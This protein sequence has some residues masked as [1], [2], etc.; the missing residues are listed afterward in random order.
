MVCARPIGLLHRPSRDQLYRHYFQIGGTVM[1]W[2]VKVIGEVTRTGRPG[3]THSRSLSTTS[4]WT[5]KLLLLLVA[6]M[7][8][9]QLLAQVNL[10]EVSGQ[11][12]DESGAALP[13]ASVT[14]VNDQT[15]IKRTTT[16]DSAGL[17]VLPALPAGTYVIIVEAPGFASQRLQFT[18]QAGAILGAPFKLSVATAQQQ[19]SVS[20]NAGLELETESHQVGGT[21]GTQQLTQLP[22]SGRNPLSY[23]LVEPG[24][25][26]G[27]D[28]AVSTSSAQFFG[29]TSNSIVLGGALDQQTGYLQDGVENVTLLTQT[30]NILP[31]TESIGEL[32]VITNGADA[33][34]RQPGIISITTKGGANSFHG[35]AYDFLQNDDLNA[36]SYNL[37]TTP[38]VKTPLRYNLFGANIGGPIVRNHAFFF[39]D[40]SGLRS[41]NSTTTLYRVPTA[42]ELQGDFTGDQTLYDPTS[43][44]P[45]TKTTV[46]YVSETG[47]NAIP[48]GPV[49]FDKFAAAYSKY[50]PAAN[51]PLNTALNANYSVPLRQTITNNQYLTRGDWAISQR[52]Q[53]Y[54]AFGYADTPTTNP[55][56][57]PGLF[58]RVYEGKATNVLSEETHVF[59]PRLVNSARFGY[60]RSNYFETIQGAG[61]ENYDQIFGLNNLDPLPNQWAP[62]T[63]AL[64]SIITL[65]YA[66]APQGA[67]QNRFQGVD[68]INLV[69]GR[70]SLFFGV[71]YIRTLFDGN[72]VIANNGSYTFNGIFTSQYTAGVRSKTN[73]GN[74]LADFLLGYPATTSGATGTSAGNFRETE[75]AGFVQDDWKLTQKLT[76]NLGLRYQFDNPPNDA[77]GHSSIYDAPSNQTIPGTWR[78]NYADFA[79]RLGFAYSPVQDTVVRGGAGIYYSQ[80]PYNY[81]QFL[82]AHAPNFIPQA[83]TFQI[84]NR[85]LTENVFVANPSA[86]GQVPQTLGLHAPDVSAIEY[87]LFVEHK[88][89]QSMVATLGYAGEGG[90]HESE[91]LNANQPD[92]IAA[93]TSPT[94]YNQRPL[95]Y[96]GDVFAQYNI[97]SSNS[98]ELQAKL[99]TQLKGGGR[100]LASYAWSKALNIEDG[101]RFTLPDEY[102][103]R[104]TYALAAWDRTNA[105]VLSTVYPLPFGPGQRFANNSGYFTRLLVAGWQLSG[106]YRAATGL[107]VSITQ[108]NVLNTG[109]LGTSFAQKICD[110][111]SGFTRSKAEWFNKACFVQTAA[112]T[113]G[114]GGRAGVRNAPINNLDFGFDKSF[115]LTER[116][117]LQFRAEAF[118]TFNHPQFS[119]PGSIAVSS[120]SLGAIT[121][122]SPAMRTMQLALRYSF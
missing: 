34:Y 33:R 38:Q 5:R 110:P 99:D 75:I 24:T 16:S 83:P 42:A 10:G 13:K 1:S 113:A 108:T 9:G 65:G 115:P 121:G 114:A 39:F 45:T 7:G 8:A 4:L 91:R 44:N 52:D 51:I 60:N 57:V 101:D 20:A 119:L 70:H 30:A 53:V 63:V 96:I 27:S 26:A 97:G 32:A 80:P 14:A 93:G 78:T 77:N 66:F 47:N 98:N 41:Q 19:V 95:S 76:L 107:P 48:G 3:N 117:Q 62:P 68:Q 81:I 64:S 56:L 43:Y 86:V 37:T 82:L 12:T 106:I 79:P 122:T 46:S 105:F 54:V 89:N 73:T 21:V 6:L 120:T 18:V 31:S 88:F 49:S 23:A 25:N 94:G 112:F 72:W 84:S 28:P 100:I 69:R 22:V 15:A 11:I 116:Q 104:S 92:S 40:Y 55:T 36:A 85:T 118:N 109:S 103:T 71:D 58:G 29:N 74:A 50:Y 61:A 90:R 59:S 111:R 67:I 17:Y 87:N 35:T 102:H 2:Y